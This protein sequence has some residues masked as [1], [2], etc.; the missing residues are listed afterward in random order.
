[1]YSF[2]DK[3]YL[4]FSVIMYCSDWEMEKEVKEKKGKKELF[5]LKESGRIQV[6]VCNI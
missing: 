3:E 6:K 5:E 1:M 2:Y 4:T